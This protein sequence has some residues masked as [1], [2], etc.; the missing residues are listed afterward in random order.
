MPTN[1]MVEPPRLKDLPKITAAANLDP[2]EFAGLE[3]ST[4]NRDTDVEF[5]GYLL[6]GEESVL[7]LGFIKFH[8]TTL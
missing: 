4:H 1:G 6:D 8:R 3:Q 2:A 5:F 7:R